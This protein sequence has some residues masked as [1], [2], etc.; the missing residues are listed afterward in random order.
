L[1]ETA[2]LRSSWP[3]ALARLAR[4]AQAI[5]SLM[6]ERV[7]FSPAG[8]LAPFVRRTVAT[9]RAFDGPTFER[10]PS[11]EVD[12]VAR[13]T[14]AGV[15]LD[16]IGARTSALSKA[17]PA[18]VRRA[19][20]MRFK[21]GGA[22]PFFGI[23]IS[24]LTDRTLSLDALW[25]GDGARLCD[26]LARTSEAADGVKLLEQALVTHLGQAKLFE[27]AAATS[28]RRAVRQIRESSEPV[29]IAELASELG[30]S[31]RNLRRAFH[32]VVGMGPKA[33]A[34]VVRFQRALRAA[35]SGAQPEWGAIAN[36][37]GYYDQSH[38][39]A[40]FRA[41]AGLT[42]AALLARAPRRAVD[43]RRQTAPGAGGSAA[44]QLPASSAPA[45]LSIG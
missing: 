13:F 23:P 24:E 29:R 8:R 16:V 14:G 9:A 18:D 10:L 19:I 17:A 39:I 33:F 40:E 43:T 27:P 20:V 28:V 15:L 44:A 5:Q 37:A 6:S 11:G 25:G 31:A 21:A 12:L 34:R 35:R 42:P 4:V 45:S 22:Y 36:A 38:L 3:E 32:D 1:E 2:S 7:D 26:A 41:L 30:V